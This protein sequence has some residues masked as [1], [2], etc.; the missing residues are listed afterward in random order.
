LPVWFKLQRSGNTFT[1]SQS[2]DGTN[3][4]T[5]GSSS[6]TMASN[7][8][9]GVA[10]CSRDTAT[11]NTTT[12]DNVTTDGVT[13]AAWPPPIPTGL[14]AS[15][16]NSQVTLTWTASTGATSNNVKRATVSGGPYTTIATVGAISRYT[17]ASPANGTKYYYV[18]S[19]LNAFGESADSSEV[20]L[21]S[22]FQYPKLT[23]ATGAAPERSS[24]SLKLRPIIG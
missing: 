19:A 2:L 16:G 13:L 20:P 8:L 9:V 4:F 10:V 24:S 17:N 3:W 11:L 1:G 18:V 22:C 14:W 7:Y 15:A 6:V 12:I 21:R 5:V 23:N